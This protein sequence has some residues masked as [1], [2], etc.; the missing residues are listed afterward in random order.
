MMWRTF[1]SQFSAAALIAFTILGVSRPIKGAREAEELTPI[2]LSVQEAPIA[3]TGSDERIHLVYELWLSNFSSGEASIE[4]VEVLG[5]GV[6][7]Q[8]METTD[9]ARRLQPAGL[10]AP[11]GVLPHSTQALL[12]LHLSLPPGTTIPKQISHR[13]QARVMAAPPGHQQ[14]TSEGGATAVDRRPVARI[15]P[16]LL[17]DGFISADAC[18][19]ATRHT[20]AALPANGRVWIAQRFAVD[21]EQI[22]QAHRIYSGARERPESYSI[23]G[24]PAIAVADATVESVTDGFPE[25]TPGQYPTNIS[26]DKADGNSVTLDLG[27]HRYALYAHLRPGSIKVHPKETVRRGQVLGLVGNSGN[28][29]APHLHFQVTDGPSSLASNGLPYEIDEFQISGRSGGTEAFDKAEGDGTPLLL[30][31]VSPA[32]LVRGGLPLDQL[33]ISFVPP[34]QVSPHR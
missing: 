14:L 12:F 29:V 33:I 10:R 6:V 28:S 7:L 22:D 1:N 18:C 21:W 24:K 2:L 3:F 34:L 4:K 15:G 16:P 17:G 30:T 19:D 26:L 20:R 32:Q 11:T 25:E 13:V 27:D 8:S 23:F 9:V 31:P 5:D